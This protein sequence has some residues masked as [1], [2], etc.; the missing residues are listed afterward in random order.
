MTKRT[1]RDF[2][3]TVGGGSIGAF[4][5]HVLPDVEL[6]QPFELERSGAMPRALAQADGTPLKNLAVFVNGRVLQG[7]ESADIKSEYNGL[8][9]YHDYAPQEKYFAT[10]SI[11][12]I[13]IVCSVQE[14]SFEVGEAVDIVVYMGGYSCAAKALF[15]QI[16]SPSPYVYMQLDFTVHG[17][18]EV[19]HCQ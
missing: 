12:H 15:S 11:T 5:L 2:L 18:L 7:C 17:D 8:E 14:L 3:K 19:E 4:L 6:D 9:F 16:Y 10:F 13:D 1:R